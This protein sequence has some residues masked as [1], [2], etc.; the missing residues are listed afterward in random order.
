MKWKTVLNVYTMNADFHFGQRFQVGCL[1]CIKSLSIGLG[2]SV[3][4]KQNIIK[5][6]SHLQKIIQAARVRSHGD[7]FLIKVVPQECCNFQLWSK[8]RGNCHVRHYELRRLE[9]ARTYSRQTWWWIIRHDSSY[10]G[11]CLIQAVIWVIWSGQ[12]RIPLNN[13]LTWFY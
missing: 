13:Q 3:P 7:S 10:R 11:G 5:I 6:D 9:S 8:L 4:T 1:E 2:A 12:L